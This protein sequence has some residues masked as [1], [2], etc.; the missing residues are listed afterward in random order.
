MTRWTTILGGVTI[1]ART[2][3]MIMIGA[4]N[5]CPHRFEQPDEVRLGRTNA[6]EQ[7]AFARGIHSCLGQ[8]LARAEAWVALGR[9]LDRTSANTISETH[10]PAD[11]R[12][13]EYGP[14]SLFQGLMALHLEF[15]A[16]SA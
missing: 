15:T 4:V 11:A 7:I 8:P 16:V 5:R 2:T 6:H 1:P 14:S 3:V 9:I 13:Y 10:G 12:R